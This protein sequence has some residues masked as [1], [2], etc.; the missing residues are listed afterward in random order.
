MWQYD[1]GECWGLTSARRWRVHRGAAG[2]VCRVRLWCSLPSR[3]C[4]TGVCRVKTVRST[5]AAR[6]RRCATGRAGHGRRH[7]GSRSAQRAAAPMRGRWRRW[8]WRRASAAARLGGRP[9]DAQS[10]WRSSR[11]RS[12]SR[13]A[14]THASHPQRRRQQGARF[15]C[16]A[17]CAHVT[18]AAWYHKVV[19]AVCVERA[20]GNTRRGTRRAHTSG[21]LVRPMS[22]SG[23]SA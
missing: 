6:C 23:A 10:G 2:A 15:V 5:R 13:R 22:T 17:P 12:H 20:R 4:A 14:E 11:M 3:R 21:W 8:R 9:A 1:V 19:C 18:P 7:T 16:A